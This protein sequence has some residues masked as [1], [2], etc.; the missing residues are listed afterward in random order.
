MRSYVTSP[1]HWDD[2][3]DVETVKY[4]Y[5]MEN[6]EW[7]RDNWVVAFDKPHSRGPFTMTRR[8]VREAWQFDPLDTIMKVD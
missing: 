8:I 5:Y 6:G 7:V 2:G 4:G 3:E 1:S